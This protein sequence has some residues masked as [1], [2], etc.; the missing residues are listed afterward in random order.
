[1]IDLSILVCSVHTR[2]KTFLPLI[3]EQIWQQY[4]TLSPEDQDRI[5][6]LILSDNKKRM[7]GEKRNDL[8]HLAKGK[9]V[10]FID[11]DDRIAP[12]M[13]QK[14]LDAT[15]SN[16][17]VI[18]HLAE[19]TINGKN[20]KICRYSKNY[21]KDYNLP[22]EYRR[23]PNHICCVKR[24]LSIQV[25]YPNIVYGED[26]PYA[27]KLKPLLQTEHAI[28]EVLYYYDYN[29]QTTE[30]QEYITSVDVIILSN[31][32]SQKLFRMT[33]QSVDSCRATAGVPVR[34]IVVEQTGH[35]YTGAETIHN[36][37]A[38]NY[39]RFA[40]EAI[41]TGTSEW[42]VIA[43]NDLIFHPG[44]LSKLLETN[45]PVMSPRNPKDSRQKNVAVNLS[46]YDNF[47]NFSGWCYMMKRSIWE[48]IGGLDEC[49]DFWCSDDVVIEQLKKIGVPPMVVSSST[50]EH[51]ASQTLARAS[52]KQNL[53]YG[54]VHQFVQK[55]G[56]HPLQDSKAY[57]AWVQ[58]NR[59]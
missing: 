5:E 45:Y 27:A 37:G 38:F 16:A 13:F 57:L 49:V 24:D 26:A 12:D 46:G 42:V 33:Q 20:K 3:Q 34:V 39:N 4:A 41:Q 19:V 22:S 11:D 53:M 32:T 40:N 56:Y 30:P 17:D 35:T 29:S 58:R 47:I 8:V 28:N 59:L 31:A 25:P 43:N 55:Y 54:G 7:L 14:L 48:D 23:L 9:Y 1:M 50:V 2:Y 15:A 10:Q 21:Q 6:I 18:T 51:L 36:S 44:W 52:D